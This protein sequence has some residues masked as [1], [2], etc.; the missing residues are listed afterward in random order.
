MDL[1]WLSTRIAELMTESVNG[2][3]LAFILPLL[4]YLLC[5]NIPKFEPQD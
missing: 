3:D 5:M 1:R 4:F 2:I